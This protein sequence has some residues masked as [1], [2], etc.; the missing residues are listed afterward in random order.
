[1]IQE[2]EH[3]QHYKPPHNETP[4]QTKQFTNL[5]PNLIFSGIGSINV[6][7]PKLK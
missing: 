2:Q 5:L 7:I 4:N 6:F 3:Q 1:M